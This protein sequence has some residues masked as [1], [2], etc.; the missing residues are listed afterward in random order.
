MENAFGGNSMSNINYRPMSDEELVERLEKGEIQTNPD[1]Y[2]EFMRRMQ[3]KGTIYHNTP[4]DEEK[5]KV[6]IAS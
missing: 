1:L 6:D 4:E 5:W 2:A 3:E